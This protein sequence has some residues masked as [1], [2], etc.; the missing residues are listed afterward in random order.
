MNCSNKQYGTQDTGPLKAIF[1]RNME[2]PNIQ[3]NGMCQ[4]RASHAIDTTAS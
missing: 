2:G 4:W 3:L 1:V